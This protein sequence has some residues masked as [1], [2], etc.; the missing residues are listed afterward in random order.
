ML[1]TQHL[2]Y[3][4][5]SADWGVLNLSI[6]DH[7]VVQRVHFHPLL[8]QLVTVVIAVISY[9]Y[10]SIFVQVEIQSVIA[11]VQN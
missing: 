6:Y 5:L 8:G 1:D 9:V 10:F 2:S 11:A 4:L 7:I 3:F